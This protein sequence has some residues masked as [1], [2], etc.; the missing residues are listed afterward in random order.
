ME[1]L[2]LKKP[3]FSRLRH[4]LYLHHPFISFAVIFGLAGCAGNIA[5][6]TDYSPC[7]GAQ[8]VT[9]C[10]VSSLE[11]YSDPSNPGLAY[12]LGFVEF[13]DQGQLYDR[14]QMHALLDYLYRAA[15]RDD[16]LMTVFVHG[17][18]HNASVNDDNIAHFRQSLL[19]LSRLERSDARARGRQPRKVV[20]IYLGWRGESVT[21]PVL[22][23]MTFYGRKEAA[24][25]VGHGGVTELF[26]R[27]EEIRDTR[28]S[29]RDGAGG[30]NRLVVVGHSFGGAVVFSALSQI[31][32][33]RFVDT[34]G[35]VGTSSNVRGFGDLVILINPAFEA[36]QFATLSD[37]ANERATYFPD[38]A[39]VLAILT[40][41]ADYATKYAFWA[42]RA[43]STAFDSHR[44]VRRLNKGS[45]REQ[46]IDQ[47]KA[48]RNTVGH[49]EPYITHRLD[50]DRSLDKAEMLT[51]LDSVR[52][53]WTMDAPGRDIPFRGTVLR[54]LDKSVT[55]N[56]YLNI[57]VDRKIIPGHNEIY[58]PRVLDFLAN[59]IMLSTTENEAAK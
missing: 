33:E 58:D 44:S 12:T 21:V 20:G 43:L 26:A 34:R 17:W 18:H 1:F 5:Y 19:M 36:A 56:P 59:L 9:E 30:A 4:S 14:R 24:Q 45:G 50:S 40:S 38:Q 57:E 16:L 47:G 3:L 11:E 39:P 2:N 53:G 46:E 27:L 54:H 25:T 48:D 42:G 49:F 51:V 28:E 13:D 37:M 8:P 23:V 15:A 22:N 35:P 52:N 41:E 6:R 29:V 55:R 10:T 31:L 32:M 7:A